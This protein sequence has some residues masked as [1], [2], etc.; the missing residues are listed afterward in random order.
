MTDTAK[1]ILAVMLVA[2]CTCGAEPA[3][4]PTN[5]AVVICFNGKLDSGN[6]CS[7]TCFQPDGTL[8]PTGKMT[9]GWPGKVSEIQWRFLR[10]KGNADVYEFTRRFPSDKPESKT[11]NKTVEFSAERT[12]IFEDIFQVIVIQ[13]PKVK[14]G[15]EQGGGMVR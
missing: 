14:D 12:I 7:G 1:L 3:T 13:S 4:S 10:R 9:C 5:K 15:A 6:Y 8:H 2:C 11:E